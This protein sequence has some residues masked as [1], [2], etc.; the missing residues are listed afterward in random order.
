MS[1]KNILKLE[2]IP[3]KERVKGINYEAGDELVDELDRRSKIEPDEEDVIYE[4]N[5]GRDGQDAREVIKE[6]DPK[7]YQKLES[8]FE[9]QPLTHHD[10]RTQWAEYDKEFHWSEAFH[11]Y[12][13]G[14][15]EYRELSEDVADFIRELGYIVNQTHAIT[16]NIYI[17]K[18]VR[19]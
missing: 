16:H 18:I 3:E 5:G 2:K 19:K 8:H 10:Y 11:K 7:L 12:G 13:M 14:D 15:S 9:S 4:G 1:W 6:N 17:K